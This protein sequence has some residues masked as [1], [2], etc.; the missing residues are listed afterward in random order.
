MAS[1]CWAPSSPPSTLTHCLTVASSQSLEPILFA[2][3]RERRQT[4]GHQQRGRGRRD[5]G[6]ENWSRKLRAAG[7]GWVGWR[8]TDG[9]AGGGRGPTALE[10]EEGDRRL[11]QEAEGRIDKK[12]RGGGERGWAPMDGWGLGKMH[13]GW[14]DWGI[15]GC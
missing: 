10:G 13:W 11:T 14:M 12:R 15:G 8:V 2:L 6:W 4:L 1:C 5:I 9:R 7:D 3:T